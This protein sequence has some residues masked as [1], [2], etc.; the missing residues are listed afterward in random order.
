M[1]RRHFEPL[2][3]ATWTRTLR[4]NVR[5]FDESRNDTHFV[6]S[7]LSIMG[8][9]DLRKVEKE[10]LTFVL[11]KEFPN[12]DAEDLMNR[13]YSKL[14]SLNS[15]ARFFNPFFNV[16]VRCPSILSLYLG[17]PKTF[18]LLQ[19]Q[20]LQRI[21]DDNIIIHRAMFVPHTRSIVHGLVMISRVCRD[22]GF[23]II[24]RALENN[25]VQQ[26]LGLAFY[27]TDVTTWLEFLPSHVV[28]EGS[29]GCIYRSGGK[30]RHIAVKT[31]AYWLMEVFF[32]A[33]RFESD[34][35]APVFCI[36]SE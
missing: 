18:L 13:T 9:R 31:A 3:V 20:V 24:G 17:Y 32:M 22:E 4:K 7:G 1:V 33:L 29:N 36:T 30:M 6:T 19:M 15:Y 11:S 10:T 26:R 5:E 25:P 12:T 2:D 14:T 35:I 23:L 34:M 27:W 28:N 8:W 21:N 16:K